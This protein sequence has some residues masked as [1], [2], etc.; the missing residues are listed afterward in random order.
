MNIKIARPPHPCIRRHRW[1]WNIRG[2]SV[3]AGL[4]AGDHPGRWSI[5]IDPDSARTSLLRPALSNHRT[6]GKDRTATGR[7]C[8]CSDYDWPEYVSAN[9]SVADP[10]SQRLGWRLKSRGLTGSRSTHGPLVRLGAF[11]HT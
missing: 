2:T 5:P 3:L 8:A 11:H 4:I 1:A 9:G 6:P 10:S 7:R